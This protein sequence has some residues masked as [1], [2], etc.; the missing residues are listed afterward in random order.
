[1]EG[2]EQEAAVVAVMV[3]VEVE[4]EEVVAQVVAVQ[5]TVPCWHPA[6]SLFRSA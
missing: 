6:S 1:M 3:E 4:A 5:T 2:E